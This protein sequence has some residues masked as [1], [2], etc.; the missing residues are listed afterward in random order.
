MPSTDDM[1]CARK[2]LS[3]QLLN[4]YILFTKLLLLAAFERIVQCSFGDPNCR[5]SAAS[6]SSTET[7]NSGD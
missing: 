7:Q 3:T 5:A 1:R 6:R 2:H 4:L